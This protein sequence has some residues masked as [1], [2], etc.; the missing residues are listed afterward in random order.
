MVLVK[1]G[2]RPAGD[3]QQLTDTLGVAHGL[4]IWDPLGQPGTDSTDFPLKCYTHF[5]THSLTLFLHISIVL[6]KAFY[7]EIQSV[8]YENAS[9]CTLVSRRI[10]QTHQHN[11]RS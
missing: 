7:S 3:G 6:K 9:R 11:L 4:P 2:M 8:S 5:C 1:E 10:M